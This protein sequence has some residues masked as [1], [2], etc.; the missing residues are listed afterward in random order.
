M[1]PKGP[2][3]LPPICASQVWEMVKNVPYKR[4]KF[5]TIKDNSQKVMTKIGKCYD[6]LKRFS[7]K[8]WLVQ[9][10]SGGVHYHAFVV[11]KPDKSVSY[12]KGI[13]IKVMD[14]GD[15]VDYDPDFLR[16]RLDKA[17]E[18]AQEAYDLT[19]DEKH[20]GEIYAQ[21][22]APPSKDYQRVARILAKS[23]KQK[24]VDRI[25]AYLVKNLNENVGETLTVYTHYIIK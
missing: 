14:V 25:V 16:D 5:F 20:A 18:V 2:L 13:H 7:E 19:G 17:N 11:L 22:L 10:P 4:L 12:K 8:I 23:K 6:Y 15:K 9:S 24:H 21:V 1:D 3:I